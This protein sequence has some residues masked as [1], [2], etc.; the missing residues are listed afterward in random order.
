MEEKKK[1]KT[2]SKK[3]FP[4]ED[5]FKVGKWV[6]L[7]STPFIILI[8]MAIFGLIRLAQ[9][10]NTN[11]NAN[12]NLNQTTE[13]NYNFSSSNLNINTR[14][15]SDF[16]NLIDYLESRLGTGLTTYDSDQDTYLDGEEVRNGF[17]PKGRGPFSG[18]DFL[19]FCQTNFASSDDFN[20]KNICLFVADYI[21]IIRR[22]AQDESGESDKDLDEMVQ[23]FCQENSA[24]LADCRTA[25]DLALSLYMQGVTELTNE[26]PN[27]NLNI[28]TNTENTDQ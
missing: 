23:N 5:K 22:M 19:E 17:S 11:A 24:N 16:D 20:Y 4:K 3:N 13:T 15:D 27:I 6:V 1:K 26:L 18:E 9:N 7:I 21:E 28:S 14:V 12:Q 25:V 8:V 2:T 10:A